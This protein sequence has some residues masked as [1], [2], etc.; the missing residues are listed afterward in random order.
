MCFSCWEKRKMA[1]G[2]AAHRDASGLRDCLKKKLPAKDQTEICRR[3]VTVVFEK[4][5]YPEDHEGKS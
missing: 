4:N 2:Q 1:S 3:A 5:Y